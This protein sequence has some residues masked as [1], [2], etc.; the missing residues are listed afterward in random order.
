MNAP[1]IYPQLEAGLD[2]YPEQPY[3]AHEH[4]EDAW[5]D[6]EGDPKDVLQALVQ[7]CAA[8]VKEQQGN[9]QGT[10]KLLAKAEGRL[11]GVRAVSVL[12]LDVVALRR[13]VQSARAA[14][15]E[16]A[17]WQV[18]LPER[19]A[20]SG[21]LYLHGFA[22]SPGSAKA[23]AIAP[24]LRADGHLVRVPDLNEGG[25][26]HLTVSRALEQARR[27]LF[28]R[29]LV[30]GSSL[31]GYIGCLLQRSDPRVKAMVLMAPAFDFAARLR[32]RE[33]A[34]AIEAWR[35]S[36]TTEVEH[37][38]YGE[39]RPIRY[40]LYE[41]AL[42][43]DARP[44]PSVPTYVLQGA[45]DDVVPADVVREVVAQADGPVQLDVVDDEHGLVDSS[46]RALAAARRLAPHLEGAADRGEV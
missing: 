42:R 37:Y 24:A 1:T 6:A 35:A 39:R 14:R 43:L 4:F 27:L 15:A 9:L 41:D 29:T 32:A 30:I 5:R 17:A 25:F 13:Q 23:Q 38:G 3:E 46:A 45:R 11:E 7:V 40:G 2:R 21:V 26:E 8:R 34:A 31:G 33:G 12:G 18:E 10:D 36:G 19:T 16:G 44:A 28:D 20:P 22:S